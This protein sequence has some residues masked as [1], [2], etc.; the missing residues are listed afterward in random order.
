MGR[1]GSWLTSRLGIE[2]LKRGL[3]DKSI[4][5]HVGW[6]FTLGS[7]CL[8]L[9]LLQA[10][11]GILLVLYYVPAPGYAYESLVHLMQDVPL[12]RVLR[13]I[14]YYG[15]SFMVVLVALYGLR[16]FFYGAYKRPREITWAGGIILAILVIAFGFT[17]YFLPWDQKAYWATV[18]GTQ[19]VGTVPL[20][21]D[22]LKHTL[23]G[24]QR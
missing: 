10:I 1:L 12:G 7:A 5:P 15:S 3:L 14:H 9:F 2:A 21:G 13:G 8:F 24:G 6:S 17:S 4:G 22:L 16:V 19:V 18:V 11:T 20:I 23:Q